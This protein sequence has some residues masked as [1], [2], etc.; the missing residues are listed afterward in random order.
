MNAHLTRSQQLAIERLIESYAT[1][2]R[3]FERIDLR[4]TQLCQLNL[5]ESRLRWADFTGTDLSHTQLN[6]ADMSG[7]MMW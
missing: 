4:E 1:G 6:H 7:A 5:S 3:Y 2:H